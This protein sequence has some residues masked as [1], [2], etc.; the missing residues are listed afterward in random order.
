MLM[1]QSKNLGLQALVFEIYTVESLL[2]Y[3]EYSTDTYIFA[4]AETCLVLIFFQSM[5][6]K[7][8]TAAKI[9]KISNNKCSIKLR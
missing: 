1:R 9:R 8:D 4:N 6:T 2:T 5:T 3:E 7:V